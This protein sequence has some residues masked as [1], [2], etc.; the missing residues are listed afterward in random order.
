MGV[1]LKMAKIL[2]LS[3]GEILW[4][5]EAVVNVLDGI[6]NSDDSAE[7]GNEADSMLTHKQASKL[8]E[9]INDL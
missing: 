8:K 9:K 3:E 5:Q 1:S 6:L 4:L 2:N 7:E